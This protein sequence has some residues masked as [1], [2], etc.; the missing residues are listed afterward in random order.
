MLFLTSFVF[1]QSI[2]PHSLLATPGWMSADDV[3][4]KA[5]GMKLPWAELF[6]GRNGAF[7]ICIRAENY[8]CISSV[9]NLFCV[10]YTLIRVIRE[11]GVESISFGMFANS[12]FPVRNGILCRLLTIAYKTTVLLKWPCLFEIVKKIFSLIAGSF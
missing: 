3:V 8:N 2:S 12:W 10:F 1:V 7:G 5:I 4:W 11:K 9:S 6:I